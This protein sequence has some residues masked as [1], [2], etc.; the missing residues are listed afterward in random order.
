MAQVVVITGRTCNGK[1]QLARRLG[2]EFRWYLRW[3]T[4]ILRRGALRVGFSILDTSEILKQQAK[5]RSVPQDRL[6]LQALGDKLDGETNHK[7]VFDATERAIESGDIHFP[8]VI[9]NIRN[10]EQLAYFRQHSDWKLT[11]VHLYAPDDVLA[12]RFQKRLQTRNQPEAAKN[13]K[14][15]DLIKQERDIE[16][17]KADADV[18]IFTKRTDSE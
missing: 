10:A 13:F 18:R 6:S 9:D 17:F 3:K 4:Q 2:E 11:H 12:E 14:E 5:A 16:S 7:W 1:T 8:I 15:A